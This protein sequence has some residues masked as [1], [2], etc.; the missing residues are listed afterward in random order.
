MRI[1]HLLVAALLAGCNSTVQ[2]DHDAMSDLS[3][4]RAPSD[5]AVPDAD[6]PRGDD[7]SDSRDAPPDAAIGRCEERP[8][9]VVELYPAFPV[10]FA[11]TDRGCIWVWGRG[12]TS[13][14]FGRADVPASDI[15]ELIPI[16]GH[17]R[18]VHRELT[19]ICGVRTDDN[20]AWC[21][22]RGGIVQLRQELPV[23]E[24]VTLS[25]SGGRCARLS[26]R[27]VWCSGRLGSIPQEFTVPRRIDE[28][29]LVD[30]L[31]A[32][33]SGPAS[34]REGEAI[35]VWHA[36]D[37]PFTLPTPTNPTRDSCFH[38]DLVACYVT[39]EGTVQ[40]AG[41][42]NGYLVT[43]SPDP[44][45]TEVRLREISNLTRIIEVSGDGQRMA[46]LRDDGTLWTWG[47]IEIRPTH[48]QLVTTNIP[49]Q[50]G[51]VNDAVHMTLWRDTM[52]FVRR[53]GSVWKH[54]VDGDGPATNPQ[55]RRVPLFGEP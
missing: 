19:S 38:S 13:R 44:E 46:A 16:P 37:P 41:A 25:E 1:H 54:A 27:S 55:L 21:W 34:Y 5:D 4:D 29:G 8:S 24:V 51:A 28:L 10:Q 32:C 39:R 26:D 43:G 53:D 48:P 7:A 52:L 49:V 35:R 12:G 14:A 50:V 45:D 3:P 31:R 2:P 42:S 11:L 36:P 9:R 33:W 18:S 17:F 30:H 40:C 6:A 47:R 20:T 23:Q 15:P 22:T